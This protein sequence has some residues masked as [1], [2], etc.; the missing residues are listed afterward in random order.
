MLVRTQLIPKGDAGTR[1]IV[2]KMSQLVNRGAIHPAV[3]RLALAITQGIPGK[4]GY[5]QI[6]AIRSWLSLHIH[7]TRDPRKNELLI[8]PEKLAS[9]YRKPG[10]EVI[11][12]IDCDDVAML[13]AALGQS[14]GLDARFVVVG[15][16]GPRAPFRHVWAELAAPENASK[17]W[18]EMD[19]TRQQQMLPLNGESAIK[20]K[21]IVR[22]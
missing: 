7:F 2:R 21:W 15:F 16:L 8:S 20:R 12:R 13:A 22:L 11:L 1:R 14:I 6:A 19:V 18:I 10:N 17:R 4:E 5:R 9:Y 3:R